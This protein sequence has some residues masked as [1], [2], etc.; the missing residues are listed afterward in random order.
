M[1]SRV[2]NVLDEK[3][4]TEVKMEEKENKFNLKQIFWKEKAYL[5]LVW[6]GLFA[7]LQIVFYKENF[8]STVRIS[9]SIYFMS[10]VAGFSWMYYWYEKLDFLERLV[11]GSV[12][13]L[14]LSGVSMYYLSFIGIGPKITSWIMP[15]LFGVLGLI[16]VF[17]RKR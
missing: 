3:I 13:G 16:F 9:L 10:V 17:Y 12:L 15:L 1:I 5:F 6:L 4:E 14:A 8:L 7:I 2:K 11:L